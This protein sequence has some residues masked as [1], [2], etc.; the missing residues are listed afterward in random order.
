MVG[1]TGWIDFSQPIGGPDDVIGSMAAGLGNGL[2]GDIVTR[3]SANAGLALCA[4][5]KMAS[6]YFDDRIWAVVHGYPRWKDERYA[7]LA[8]DLGSARALADGYRDVGREILQKLGGPCSIAVI[9]LTERA[10]L[11][12]IDRMGVETMC[13]AT[14]R[15]GVLVFGSRTDAVRGHPS[16][17]ATISPQALY[18]YVQSFVV[19][20]PLTIFKEQRKLQRGQYVEVRNGK[21][22]VGTYWDV[23]YK[24][25]GP[26]DEA[27]LMQATRDALRDGVARAIEGEDIGK[28]G[29]YLSGG[30]DSSTVSGFLK[31]VGGRSRTFT[32]GFNVE[33]FDETPFARMAAERFQTE[34]TEVFVKPSD[35]LDL[36]PHIGEI[37]DEPFGNASLVPAFYCAKKAKESGVELML[38]G[39]GGDELFG[40]NKH[41]T[42]M[43]RIESYANIPAPLRSLLIEPVAAIPGL[44][45]VGPVH[46]ARRWIEQYRTPMPERMRDRGE[47]DH[48]QIEN[49]FEPDMLDGVNLA[50]D[51]TI[52]DETYHATNSSAMLQRMLHLDLQIVLADNDLR[53]VGRMCELAGVRVRYPMLDEEVLEVSAQIPP[54]MMIPDLRLRDFYKRTF[55]GFLP[56]GIINKKKHGFF[57]PVITWLLEKGELHDYIQDCVGSFRNRG[58]LLPG[59]LDDVTSHEKQAENHEFSAMAL[60]LSFLELWMQKHVDRAPAKMRPAAGELGR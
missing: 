23:A 29:A 16:A 8:R 1:I 48:W 45:R 18:N 10:A 28:V 22:D 53:K 44:N 51:A 55:T 42:D 20:A 31:E 41:Y 40:G 25:H 7:A 46:K 14:P 54:N 39:D 33:G 47:L 5:K 60:D 34:H 13:Y 15:P 11:V 58:I 43:L 9:D 21:A 19:L 30:L 57:I 6:T 35:V 12:T 2:D 37:Y 38:A 17:T 52:M 56:D 50:G 36:I 26:A 32:I 24:A 3:A 27:Q 4:H 59:F 49:I